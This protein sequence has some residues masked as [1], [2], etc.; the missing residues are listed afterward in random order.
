M[1][2]FI[3]KMWACTAIVCAGI[4]PIPGIAQDN[5]PTKPVRLIAPFPAGGSS[6]GLARLIAPELAKKIGQSV[7]VEN[8][9]GA[10]GNIGLDAVA[11]SEPDGY[12]IGLASPGPTVVNITLMETIPYDPVRDLTPIGLIA[13]LPILLV[14]NSAVPVRNVTELIAAEKAN[15]EKYFFASAGNGTTMHLSG[16]LF[17]T[18]AGTKLQHVAYKGTAPAIADL[19]AGQVQVGFL[20]LSSVGAHVGGKKITLLA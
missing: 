6:D 20:D 18:M 19:L 12:T 8:K 13:D 15:P 2:K 16:E 17:N 7:I 10:G 9:P 1:I 3:P 5:F 14:V 4:V 11:K